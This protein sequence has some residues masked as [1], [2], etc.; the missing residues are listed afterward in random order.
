M[1]KY[2]L[3]NP[4]IEGSFQK[5]YSG[6]DKMEV[7]DKLWTNLSKY[8]IG[9]VPRFIF[10]M[11]DDENSYHTFEV[12][13]NESNGKYTIQTKNVEVDD[14]DFENFQNAVKKYSSKAKK[15]QGGM[16]KPKR[17]RYEDD[18]SD[19]DS[20]SDNNMAMSEYYP[21]IR[22]TSPIVLFNYNTR[23]YHLKDDCCKNTTLNPRV[24]ILRIPIFAPVFVRRIRPII[25]L[26]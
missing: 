11:K 23:L 18:S 17:K 25:A 9:G 21:T 2:T 15:Q 19:T 12:R 6:K 26:Y 13:E 5:T 22:R 24:R 7:A 8:L 14:E 3:V 16:E 1:T 10:T 4:I 20:D